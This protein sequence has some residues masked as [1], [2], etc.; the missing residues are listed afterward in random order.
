MGQHIFQFPKFL[1]RKPRRWFQLPSEAVVQSLGN[2]T[3]G[4]NSM[5]PV[6]QASQ[7]AAPPAT[8]TNAV[9]GIEARTVCV[10]GPLDL[11]AEILQ[12]VQDCRERLRKYLSSTNQMGR[13]D[14]SH[15]LNHDKFYRVNAKCPGD[16]KNS[17]TVSWQGTY[18]RKN[19]W[20][21][22]RDLD[23]LPT[24]SPQPPLGR[25]RQRCSI[26]PCTTSLSLGIL[27]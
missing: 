18:Y 15:H 16:A 3:L 17:C 26:S 22:C 14:K 19:L 25:S 13:V 20:A 9:Q 7:L 23:G 4:A 27:S 21:T 8:A 6:A 5:V 11:T 24:Q 12:T 10:E 1:K 2:Q